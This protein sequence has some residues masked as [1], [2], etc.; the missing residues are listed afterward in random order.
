MNEFTS[1]IGTLRQLVRCSD[2]SG[3]GGRPEVAGRGAKR[4][5]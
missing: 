5:D 2:M 1:A 4:R 3:G